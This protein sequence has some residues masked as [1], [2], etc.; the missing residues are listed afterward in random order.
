M[1]NEDR[2][3]TLAETTRTVKGNNLGLDFYIINRAVVQQKCG[4]ACQF[5]GHYS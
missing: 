1:R 5:G 4:K 2:K 3:L